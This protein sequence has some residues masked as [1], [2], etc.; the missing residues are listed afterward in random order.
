MLQKYAVRKQQKGED[1]LTAMESFIRISKKINEA[2]WKK[3]ESNIEE[4]EADIDELLKE[5]KRGKN[6]N[7]RNV[8][9]LNK[10]SKKK[11]RLKICLK[12]H[13]RM[14]K[15]TKKRRVTHERDIELP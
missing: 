15:N 7:S 5:D 6:P 12:K 2:Q 10:K 4:M 3:F 13:R 1:P 11:N 8:K 9:N 14:L